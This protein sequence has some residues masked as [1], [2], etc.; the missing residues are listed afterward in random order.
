[1]EKA[2]KKLETVSDKGSEPG[3]IIVGNESI[4]IV[5]AKL[6]DG[7]KQRTCIKKSGNVEHKYMSACKQW[8]TE[9]FCSDFKHVAERDAKSV[10]EAKYQPARS[11]LIGT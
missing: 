3:I 1:M 9:V 5:E 8:W 6:G 2:R 10:I 11:W 7:S 4:V